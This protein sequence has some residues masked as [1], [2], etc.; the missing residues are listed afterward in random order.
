[1]RLSFVAVSLIAIAATAPTAAHACKCG[2]AS[3]AQTIEN[4][5]LVFRGQVIS[6]QTAG[7][8]HVAR[9]RVLQ[10]IK[11][12]ADGVV[13]LRSRIGI[14][15][16]GVSFRA[17]ESLTVAANAREGYYSTSRCLLRGLGR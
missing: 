3:R 12:G 5:D 8:Q 4:S 7:R 17:G 10:S 9:I 16:C 15:A 14:G 6:A 13:E 1:M 11:G 2:N